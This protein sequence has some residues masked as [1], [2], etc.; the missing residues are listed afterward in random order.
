MP[1]NRFVVLFSLL[2]LLPVRASGQVYQIEDVVRLLQEADSVSQVKF[3]DNYVLWAINAGKT[4]RLQD[5]AETIASH[6]NKAV[7]AKFK[8]GILKRLATNGFWRTR[9]Y[10]LRESPGAAGLFDLEE[11]WK[12]FPSSQF[13]TV[14]KD[15]LMLFSR[16]HEIVPA[17]A[18]EQTLIEAFNAGY[19]EYVSQKSYF[20]DAKKNQLLQEAIEI[21]NAIGGRLGKRHIL[22]GTATCQ[23][24]MAY[25]IL[26]NYEESVRLY[27]EAASVFKRKKDA[28]GMRLATYSA[29]HQIQRHAELLIVKKDYDAVRDEKNREYE[30]VSRNLGTTHILSQIVADER[31]AMPAQRLTQSEQSRARVEWNIEKQKRDPNADVFAEGVRLAQSGNYAEAVKV[32]LRC[33]SLDKAK[34]TWKDFR[35]QYTQQWVVWCYVQSGQEDRVFDYMASS[36]VIPSIYDFVEGLRVVT[37]IGLPPIDRSQTRDLDYLVNRWEDHWKAGISDSYQRQYLQKAGEVFGTNSLAYAR[38]LTHMS[39]LLY[40]PTSDVVDS[41]NRAKE[42]FAFHL[43]NDELAEAYLLEKRAGIYYSL[44]YVPDGIQCL[45]SALDI[46]AHRFGKKSRPYTKLINKLLSYYEQVDPSLDMARWQLQLSESDASLHL[47]ERTLLLSGAARIIRQQEERI[48]G[49]LPSEKASGIYSEIADLCRKKRVVPQY[50]ELFDRQRYQDIYDQPDGTDSIGRRELCYSAYCEA[51]IQKAWCGFITQYLGKKPVTAQDSLRVLIGDIDRTLALVPTDKQYE[52]FRERS[53][54]VRRLALT[55]LLRIAYYTKDYQ[56]VISTAD[57]VLQ[58]AKVLN[59]RRDHFTR[60]DT[61]PTLN[62]KSRALVALKRN[63]EADSLWRNALAHIRKAEEEKTVYSEEKEVHD[64]AFY[65]YALALQ[66]MTRPGQ[67]AA[68]LSQYVDRITPRIL[69]GLVAVNALK[70]ESYWRDKGSFFERDLPRFAYRNREPSTMCQLYDAALL[71][72]GLLLNTEKEIR[73]YLLESGDSTL[74]SLYDQWRSDQQL[75][76]QQLRHP[77]TERIVNTDSLQLRQRTRQQFIFQSTSKDNKET[78]V[79]RLLTSWADIQRKLG[80]EDAA[81]EFLTIPENSGNTLYFALTLRPGYEAPHMTVLCTQDRIQQ[82]SFDERYQTDSLHH[83]L[84]QP[85]ETELAHA[86]RVFFSPAG[87]L[88]QIGIE[89]VPG[90]PERDYYRLSSTRELIS[91]HSESRD[92][93]AVLYGGLQYELTDSERQQ[94]RRNNQPEPLPHLRDIS[95]LRDLRKAEQELPVLEGSLQ[96]VL[97]IGAILHKQNAGTVTATGLE[98]TETGFKALSGKG[99]SLIH[100]STHGFYLPEQKTREAEGGWEQLFAGSGQ[101]LSFEEQSLRRSGLLMTGAADFIFGETDGTEAE[102]GILTAEEIS[103]INLQGLDLVV[104]SACET[105][106]GDITSDG[107]F[108]FQRGFKK[109]GAG[110]ILMSLWKVD[111]EA[112][113]LL[114]TEFYKNWI[115][116]KMTKHAALEQAKNTVRSHKE[117][118]WDDP[119]YWAAFILLDALD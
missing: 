55:T 67:A 68:Y 111:D 101:T 31:E 103:Q 86:R 11:K 62:Y 78:I 32:F 96:E 5:E 66:G 19:A 98:G 91:P 28:L 49:M 45:E 117:K 114:M 56:E 106:L 53:L 40:I 30:L 7:P 1:M 27:D 13:P 39:P 73:H 42:I 20:S 48:D 51:R 93:D 35:R 90:L 41:L 100:L 82:L 8:S 105:G 23:V 9:T 34:M 95:D 10:W 64:E 6:L 36:G 79:Q 54:N 85:L 38:I 58:L 116:R 47:Y 119:K 75:L 14:G 81:V 83:M 109:A 77:Q 76:E 52:L 63:P 43:G 118:G 97:G 69:S 92:I 99:K 80:P 59:P 57:Q 44:G 22:Y 102:D 70:R 112:T 72:K 50:T 29:S 21:R 94:L 113:C 3:A 60:I 84:W 46:Y 107:V 88:H 4:Y 17:N 16:Q 115:G 65:D 74:L 26:F 24:A 18:R 33:D 87:A 61:I 89:H 104:L 2:A 110:S 37:S 12:T 15:A 108:G 71:C 25:A